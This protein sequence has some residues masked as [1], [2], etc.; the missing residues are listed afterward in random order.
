MDGN[1]LVYIVYAAYGLG[2]LLAI[3]WAVSRLVLH[4]RRE[5]EQHTRLFDLMDRDGFRAYAEKLKQ[6][7]EAAKALAAEEVDQTPAAG[8]NSDAA[9]E[10]T[11]AQSGERK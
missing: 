5:K 10:S 2:L 6:E 1:V 4:L 9:K 8:G 3:G 7:H 11:P